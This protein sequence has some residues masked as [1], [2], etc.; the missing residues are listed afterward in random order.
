MNETIARRHFRS[1]VLSGFFPAWLA[2][3]TSR[4]LFEV[5]GTATR[6]LEGNGRTSLGKHIRD[7][8]S[9]LLR[10]CGMVVDPSLTGR[11]EGWLAELP[12]EVEE[13][14]QKARTNG[15]LLQALTEGGLL[16][17]Y[18]FPV[19]VVGLSVPD[20]EEEE[21]AYESQDYYSA[22]SR[23]LRV[24]ITEYAPGAEIV[25]GRFPKTYI[26]RSAGLYDPSNQNP[27]YNPVEQ[28]VECRRCRAVTLLS[29]GEPAPSACS[30]CGF[31]DLMTI[32]YLRPPGFTV[33]AALPDAGRQEYRSGGR[34]RAGF[35]S[36]A[37]LLVGAN[38]L[39][40]GRPHD[41]FAPRLYS[42]V[43]VGDLF[44][45]NLGPDREQPGFLL[46]PTCGRL[47]DPD[48]PE[49]HTYPANIPPHRGF[50]TG[51]RAGTPCPNSRDNANNVAL[52][53]K[54]SSEVVLLAIDM[55]HSLDAPFIEPSGRAVWQ[56]FGT[57]MAEAAARVLQIN[58]DEI[59]IGVRPMRD[60]FGR[61]QGEV[62]IYDDVPGGAG[63]AR[64]IH[65]NLEDV[66]EVA[67]HM[68][69]DCLN[70]D[71][72][73]ACYHCLLGYRNQRVHNLLDRDL[74]VAVL[75][76]LL[77]DRQPSLVADQATGMLAGL[78][79]Y[80]RSIWKPM[81]SDP[82]QHLYSAV[83]AIERGQK[84][85][86][87]PL[88]PLSAHPGEGAMAQLLRDTGVLPKIYNTFDLSRRPFW[89]ANDLFRSLPR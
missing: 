63:Y 70:S 67:L 1:L 4:G 37:Q 87:R 22:I 35:G 73:G 14:A 89:V 59:Q 36:S 86:I 50:R 18:A 8:R 66:A 5:W 79:E 9:E 46:C 3:G 26:Y 51:P 76:Y 47:V 52:G 78:N 75:E 39:A 25:R 6:F 85:G 80:M 61:I 88:H 83:F 65:D 7:N 74:G 12:N 38:A 60:S 31:S 71:C 33:D 42:S 17:K 29:T 40:T 56:S 68:G 21:D 43:H 19:D 15:D 34:E 32:P 44:M 27:D 54:F 11:L 55:P 45:R 48:N 72:G 23:D 41:A 77:R 28:L 62:F 57:L 58:P 64:A 69:R 24:A 2:S 84:V 49:P 16:P 30:V 10:R 82:S 81:E 20:N 13:A 53:H